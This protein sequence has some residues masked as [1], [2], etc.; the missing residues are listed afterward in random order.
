MKDQQQ[1]KIIYINDSIKTNFL[2][3]FDKFCKN[4]EYFDTFQILT[5]FLPKI[6]HLDS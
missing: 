6:L 5:N 3:I 4:F 2:N 1:Q